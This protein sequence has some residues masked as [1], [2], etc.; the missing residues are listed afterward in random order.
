MSTEPF[1][2]F[3]SFTTIGGLGQIIGSTEKHWK[4]FWTILT[5]A[6]LT[7][8]GYSAMLIVIEFMKYNVVTTFSVDHKDRLVIPSVSICN[9]NRVHCGNLMQKL[10]AYDKANETRKE[11][12]CKLFKLTGCDTTT[13]VKELTVDGKITSNFGI[14]NV[15]EYNYTYIDRLHDILKQDDINQAFMEI[16]FKLNRT[17]LSDLAHSPK[18]TVQKCSMGSITV[19]DQCKQT[20][21]D[22]NAT[23]ILT[24]RYGVCY[25]HNFE[26]LNSS[27]N[28]EAAGSSGPDYGLN[29]I[30]AI[31]SHFY[32]RYGLSQTNGMIITLN[33]PNAMPMVLAKPIHLA[34]NVQT[35]IKILKQTIT[36]QKL[37]Y[38]TD[39]SDTYPT[40]YQSL[41]NFTS[42]NYTND[43]CKALCKTDYVKEICGCIDP[44]LTEANFLSQVEPAKNNF[45]SVEMNSEQRNC[46]IAAI[47]AYSNGEGDDQC[48]CKTECYKDSFD[49][50]P[51]FYFQHFCDF[52]LLVRN[53]RNQMAIRSILGHIGRA[54]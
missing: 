3:K 33:D 9:V 51:L 28:P 15:P 17:E 26:P 53:I 45:C 16:Y 6:F 5:L 34:P 48:Q 46:S 23:R 7:I 36:R 20:K 47:A 22:R 12:L 13:K 35:G 40:E 37:P 31:Q 8:T 38:V 21:D 14:C 44:L 18:S 50:R 24:P 27:T 42:V 43:Y 25:L 4:L 39:C 30:L 11:M 19:T 32:M 54:V 49:V 52:L 29:L 1:H 2:W 41:L 10:E